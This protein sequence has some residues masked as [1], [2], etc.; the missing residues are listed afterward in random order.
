MFA[1]K[2]LVLKQ[3]ADGYSSGKNPACGICRLEK[4]NGMLA[5]VLSLVGFIALPRGEYRLYI[6]SD[7]KITVKKDLGA[8][9]ASSAFA[10]DS[11]LSLENGVSVGVWAVK[12]DIPLLV[13][14]R[15]SEN[16]RLSVK[17]YR[18]RVIN[19][20]IA[21]RKLREREKTA[22]LA[23]SATERKSEPP[24]TEETR[25]SVIPAAVYDDD[26]VATENFYGVDDKIKGKLAELKDFDYE[27]IR[28]END[29]GNS[30][31]AQEDRQSEKDAYVFQNETDDKTSERTPYYDTVKDEL[32]GIFGRFPEETTLSEMFPD[33]RWAKINYAEDKFYV[34]GVVKE[35]NKEKYICYGVPS[36]YRETPPKELAGYCCFIPLSPFDLKGNGYFI[37]FQDALTGKCVQKPKPLYE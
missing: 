16:A 26:A 3:T 4:E 6:V 2:T 12:D 20:V 37:M 8:L 18:T 25:L 29:G 22:E 28:R 30:V 27:H 1:K 23:V 7:D 11:A 33:S 19:D 35:K 9:A 34:V 10:V 14:F 5:A 24:A 31:C 36:P 21:E 15:Q 17:D 32:D 13:A